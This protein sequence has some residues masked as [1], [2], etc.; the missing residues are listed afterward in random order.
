MTEGTV[1]VEELVS[2]LEEYATIGALQALNWDNDLKKYACAH[3][4][5]DQV[6]S[7]HAGAELFHNTLPCSSRKYGEAYGKYSHQDVI[8]DLLI[9]DG[10]PTR[11]NRAAIFRPYLTHVG[12]CIGL[13]ATRD[14]MASLVYQ[15]KVGPY[16]P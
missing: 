5:D 2:E 13:H 6:Y 15:G 16:C 14:T 1:A 12:T 9:D 4:Y 8:L 3:V 10:N 7:D 11:S